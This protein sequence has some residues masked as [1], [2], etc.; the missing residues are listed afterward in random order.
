MTSSTFRP[1]IERARST[2]SLPPPKPLR[3]G[4]SSSSPPASTEK[5]ASLS[6]KT[7]PAIRL[8][9]DPQHV[10][11][12]AVVPGFSHEDLDVALEKDVLRITGRLRQQVPQNLPCVKKER[13]ASDFSRTI[14]LASDVLR[15]H[16]EA[17]LEHGV[18][19]V[20][21]RKCGPADRIAIP[22]RQPGEQA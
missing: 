1:N 3:G 15:S 5:P 7:F 19:T 8:S 6:A 9:E 18:L 16:T 12:V 11:I 21:M 10:T 20:K 17:R 13:L 4:S 14:K 2:T 22:I